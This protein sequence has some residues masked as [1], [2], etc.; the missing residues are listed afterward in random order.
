MVGLPG[1]GQA[2]LDE[3]GLTM[4]PVG[5]SVSLGLLSPIPEA[6]QAPRAVG[7]PPRIPS[8][9]GRD[10]PRS[11]VVCCFHGFTLLEDESGLPGCLSGLPVGPPVQ[12]QMQAL[13]S[14]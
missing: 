2:Y 14:L 12:F 7:P 9:Q 13:F 1:Q 11:S 4:A 10:L 8:A 6:R 5:F 3:T